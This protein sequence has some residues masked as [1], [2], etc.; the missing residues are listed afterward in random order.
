MADNPPQWPG[1]GAFLDGF[2]RRGD[3]SSPATAIRAGT[4]RRPVNANEQVRPLVPG[5]ALTPLIPDE[6]RP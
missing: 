3:F 5:G 4:S 2:A 6:D 1:G